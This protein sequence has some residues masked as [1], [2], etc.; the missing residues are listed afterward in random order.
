MGFFRGLWLQRRKKAPRRPQDGPKMAPRWPHDDPKRPQ[1]GPKRP[2][3]GP[4][5]VNPS[6]SLP[7]APQPSRL[8]G[9]LEPPFGRTFSQPCTLQRAYANTKIYQS[10]STFLLES[11]SFLERVLTH[12]AWQYIRTGQDRVGGEKED[13]HRFT[14]SNKHGPICKRPNTLFQEHCAFYYAKEVVIIIDEPALVAE[15]G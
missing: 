10:K 4:Q 13:H 3:R 15:P 12:V 5:D 6:A 14:D 2:P 11:H 9:P 8:E 7:G 1:D